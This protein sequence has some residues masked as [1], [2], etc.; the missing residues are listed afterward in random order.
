[1]IG[2]H[3]HNSNDRPTNPNKIGNQHLFSPKIFREGVE[4]KVVLLLVMVPS[5]VSV[6]VGAS[7]GMFSRFVGVASHAV[8]Y[9]RFMPSK[10][11]EVYAT[12]STTD[13]LTIKPCC[14]LEA[15]V[16]LP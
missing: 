10:L 9:D 4:E 2:Y 16:V 13:K 6:I 3:I 11:S 14:P 15:L 7:L 8:A 12:P 1:M 5:S